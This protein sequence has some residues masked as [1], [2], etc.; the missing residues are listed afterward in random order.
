MLDVPDLASVAALMGDPTR[1]QILL[2]L[3]DGSARTATELALEGGV[4]PSTASSHLARLTAAGLLSI[5]RQGRHRYFRLA[6]PEV[7]AALEGLMNLAQHNGRRTSRPAPGDA[8]LRRARICYDHLAGEAGVRL[9]DRLRE[10][11]YLGG[12]SDAL[13]L[14]G[15]GEAWCGRLG[16]D[17]GALRSGRRRVCR[18]C[19]DWSERRSHLAGALGAALLE[20]LVSL[21]YARRSPHGRAVVLSR[22]GDA[23][24]ERLELSR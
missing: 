2:A 5:A 10:A 16:I 9:F 8:A 13:E 21:H 18:A 3:M 22:R 1:G 12:T 17:V 24:I 15:R 23:F 7:A 20:R 14:T 11:G 6:A 19:L 4:S